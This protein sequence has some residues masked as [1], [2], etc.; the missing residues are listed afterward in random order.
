MLL[1]AGPLPFL[2]LHADVPLPTTGS[3]TMNT[4]THSYTHTTTD[5]LYWLMTIFM[6]NLGS[7][8]PQ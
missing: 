2:L 4:P 6:V 8:V 7:L 3:C 1:A 5:T